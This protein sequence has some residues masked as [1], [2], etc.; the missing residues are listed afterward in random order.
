M[1][2]APENYG[3]NHEFFSKI[4]S[5]K[6]MNNSTTPSAI[7]TPAELAE[8][9]S[10]AF[11]CRREVQWIIESHDA[12]TQ[13]LE[14]VKDELNT[15]YQKSFSWQSM[16][17]EKWGLRQEL[18]EE[19]GI[20]ENIE[21]DAELKAALKCVKDMKI[22]LGK[23]KEALSFPQ[24]IHIRVNFSGC[25]TPESFMRAIQEAGND[26]EIQK[27]QALRAIES[28][29]PKKSDPCPTCGRNLKP[30]M[31]NTVKCPLGHT[32]ESSPPSL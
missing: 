4:S 28:S 30:L 5:I 20:G 22:A 24:G 9:G 26:L 2:F 25:K 15:A 31:K 12:L 1:N 16:A 3:D 10:W 18:K 11:L 29:P 23:A 8:M 13:A 7:L 14:N 19:L 21:D 6:I 32:F 17:Q 27:E